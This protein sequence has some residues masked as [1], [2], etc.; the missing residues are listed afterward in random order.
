MK[1]A[2]YD[3]YVNKTNG[4]TMHFDILVS[5]G[6]S[7]E[8]VIQYGHRYLATKGQDGQALTAE[9]CQFCHFE[10]ASQELKRKIDDQGYSIIEMEGC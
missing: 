3:C 1:I 8:T 7:F 5:D 2:V 10:N 6:A 9:K 4:E